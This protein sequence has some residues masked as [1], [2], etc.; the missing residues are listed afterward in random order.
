MLWDH[1]SGAFVSVH[2]AVPI[3]IGFLGF[4]HY[5]TPLYVD[6]QEARAAAKHGGIVESDAYRWDGNDFAGRI[7]A[8]YAGRTV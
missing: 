8:L 4:K 3:D 5:H 7:P 6:V 2:Y 1:V